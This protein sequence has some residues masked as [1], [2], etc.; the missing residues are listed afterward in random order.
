MHCATSENRRIVDKGE[1]LTE[2]CVTYAKA[3]G[4]LK[5]EKRREKRKREKRGLCKRGRLLTRL[6]PLTTSCVRVCVCKRDRVCVCV[7]GER[8]RE[9][10]VERERDC[11]SS[12]AMFHLL[13]SVCS[14]RSLQKLYL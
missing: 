8:E 2:H 7:C 3:L 9:E 5:A 12:S 6:K 13:L 10:Y 4:A 14:D 1:E 11:V